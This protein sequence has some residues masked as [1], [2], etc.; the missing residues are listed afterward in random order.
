MNP[1]VPYIMTN[2][3]PLNPY[4][5]PLVSS[6]H[7]SE[8]EHARWASELRLVENLREN[9]KYHKAEVEFRFTIKASKCHN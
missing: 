1:P 2:R 3:S 7:L 8:E 9:V 6:D 5:P 4:F